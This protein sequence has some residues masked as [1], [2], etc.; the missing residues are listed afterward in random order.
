MVELCRKRTRSS[1][2]VERLVCRGEWSSDFESPVL[3]EYFTMTL[4]L[5]YVPRLNDID[6]RERERHVRSWMALVGPLRKRVY[7]RLSCCVG[8]ASTGRGWREEK[9]EE[10]RAGQKLAGT[11]GR[12]RETRRQRESPSRSPPP[13]L[14]TR[15]PPPSLH[16]F[17]L[18]YCCCSGDC[19]LCRPLQAAVGAGLR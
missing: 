17:L 9:E 14:T 16:L 13:A 8:Q 3:S 18:H 2:E 5:E 19:S 4:Q 15:V 6:E 1:R 11:P 12:G 10:R 7:V